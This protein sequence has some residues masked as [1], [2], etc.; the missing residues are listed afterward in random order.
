M[1]APRAQ[2]AYYPPDVWRYL[3]ACQWEHIGQEEPFVGRTAEAG[4]DLGSRLLAAKMARCVM[5]LAFLLERRYAPYS[6]WLGTAFSRLETAAGLS[7]HLAAAL[8]GREE[9]P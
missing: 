6:K 8:A 2:L 9:P 3:L 4:D 1:A 5:R 7:A